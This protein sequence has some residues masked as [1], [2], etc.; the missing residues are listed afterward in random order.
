MEKES[1]IT[2]LEI[3]DNSLIYNQD[4]AVIDTMVATAKVY[5]RDIVKATKNA[6]DIVTIDKETAAT[7]SYAVP[8]GGKVITGVTVHMAKV[9][10]Q[11]WGNM[12]IEAKVI[13]IEQKHITSQ[14]IAFDLENN[15]AIKVEVKRSIMTRTG[16]MNDDMITVTGNAANAISLRNAILAV[17][18]RAITDKVY[19][20][21]KDKITGDLV[22]EAKFLKRRSQIFEGFEKNYK[23]TSADVLSLIGKASID[24]ITKDDLVILIG[25]AQAIKDGD[26]TVDEAFEKAKEPKEKKSGQ[27]KKAELKEKLKEEVAVNSE[28]KQEVKPETKEPE[29]KAVTLTEADKKEIE[30]DELKAAEK[31]KN[32]KTP[33]RE[34]ITPEIINN[35]K[36]THNPTLDMQ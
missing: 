9:L 35:T 4:R 34:K 29:V 16:R 23:K 13:S 8:R 24:N 33:G 2:K 36:I 21:A 5:P 25:I 20:A 17:I 18:P 14:A 10:A 6:I 19:N 26:T 3:I 7:C 31:L 12:R 22:D 15:V 32:P 1:E 28:V 27:E 11:T 30:K